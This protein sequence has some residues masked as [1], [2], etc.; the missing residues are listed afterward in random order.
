VIITTDIKLNITPP[1][2]SSFPSAHALDIFQLLSTTSLFRRRYIIVK[3][4]VSRETLKF[5]K[6]SMHNSIHKIQ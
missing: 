4:S 1:T 5:D 3:E 6:S 2:D